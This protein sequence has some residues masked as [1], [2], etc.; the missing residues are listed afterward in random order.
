MR[1]VLSFLA[2]LSAF[3]LAGSAHAA[4]YLFDVTGD[5]TLSFE[6]DDAN[7]VTGSPDALFI[8]G[9]A[10]DGVPSGLAEVLIWAGEV[11]GGFA[12]YEA[13]SPLLVI[14]G[15]GEQLFTG[16]ITAPILKVG[17]FNLADPTGALS[18]QLTISQVGAVP[19]PATWAM[20]ISGF[21]MLGAAA[22]RRGAS[23]LTYA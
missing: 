10:F 1:Q 8:S 2:A 4:T 16:P 17:S 12:L 13:F 18:Y 23:Q 19:E 22:R 5:A 21:G 11:G 20:M 15:Q 3:A 6:V 14:D 9:V 7:F